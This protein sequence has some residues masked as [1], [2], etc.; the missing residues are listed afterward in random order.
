MYLKDLCLG[1]CEWKKLFI[2]TS[3]LERY[4][5]SQIDVVFKTEKLFPKVMRWLCLRRFKFN[6]SNLCIGD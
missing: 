5:F 6:G 3:Y 4:G 1:D 2:Q